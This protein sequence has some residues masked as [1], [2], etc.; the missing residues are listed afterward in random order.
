[1]PNAE[2]RE[3]SQ[4]EEFVRLFTRH[5]RQIY[6]YISTILTNPPDAEEVL[7]E[8]SIILWSKFDTFRRGES[9]VKWACGIAHLQILRFFRQQKRRML[10]LDEP[11]IERLLAE[12]TKLEDDLTQRRAALA[13]C[14][15]RLSPQDRRVL[16]TCYAPGTK[17][18]DAAR[19]LGRPVGALYHT[20]SRIRRA[21]YECINRHLA[22]DSRG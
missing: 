14:V 15:G 4:N 13:Q 16:E 21:L 17:F 22:A 10:P 7:Q 8:T 9:F 5:Q 1:M 20:L 19:D 12:R 11:T 2:E 18:K 6:A 3:F